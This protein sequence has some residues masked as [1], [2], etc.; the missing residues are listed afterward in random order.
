MAN[1][2][3]VVK[4]QYKIKYQTVFSARYDKQ[5]EDDQVLDEIDSQIFLN[6]DKKLTE[7]NIDNID[8]TSQLKQEIQKQETKDSGC[9]FDKINSMT[10]F[11][12]K[13]TEMNGWI[14]VKFRLRSSTQLNIESVDKYC[15]F[16]SISTHLHHCKIVILIEFRIKDNILMK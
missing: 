3:A 15:F 10:I 7:S 16:R 9:R 2:Y 11:F 12:N 4:N 1:I 8:V 5:D 6:H 14:Y 13:T